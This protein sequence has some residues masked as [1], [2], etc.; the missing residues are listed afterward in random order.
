MAWL[1]PKLNKGV[2]PM[3]NFILWIKFPCF[4]YKA[5]IMNIIENVFERINFVV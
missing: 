5:E 3:L 4:I 1:I 2:G